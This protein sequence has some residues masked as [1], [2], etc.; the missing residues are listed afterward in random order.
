M[1]QRNQIH[2]HLFISPWGAGLRVDRALHYWHHGALCRR[3]Q[4]GGLHHQ[5][6]SSLQESWEMFEKWCMG[7]FCMHILR[8]GFGFTEKKISTK[9][10]Q[11]P[12]T[13][14]IICSGIYSSKGCAEKMLSL[15]FP[16][17]HPPAYSYNCFLGVPQ[18]SSVSFKSWPHLKWVS[19]LI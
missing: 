2:F 8:T 6:R 5:K 13:H 1:M 19:D 3:G 18:F 17:Q 7:S 16:Q 4:W 11:G 15:F 14:S 10:G 9:T 12:P